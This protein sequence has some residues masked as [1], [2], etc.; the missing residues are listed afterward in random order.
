MKSGTVYVREASVDK[1]QKLESWLVSLALE[2]DEV[3]EIVDVLEKIGEL[4]KGQ[5]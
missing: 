3:V 2:G 4:K 5:K 1:L